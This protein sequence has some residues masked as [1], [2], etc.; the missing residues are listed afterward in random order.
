MDAKSLTR[1]ACTSSGATINSKPRPASASR[2]LCR[3]KQRIKREFR[4]CIMS[5]SEWRNIQEETLQP[6]HGLDFI[7]GALAAEFNAGVRNLGRQHG[8]GAGD[9]AR[10][11]HTRE[12]D[13]FTASIDRKRTR[14]NSS[15]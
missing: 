3:R 9:G 4:A 12:A 11:D 6:T 1:S 5:V 14:L 15:H 8:I 7:H 2:L 10:I 13:V